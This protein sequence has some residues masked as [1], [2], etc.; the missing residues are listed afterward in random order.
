MFWQTLFCLSVLHI[1]RGGTV[2]LGLMAE[3]ALFVQPQVVLKTRSRGCERLRS[4]TVKV[5]Q[6]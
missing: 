6:W 2:A 4:T 5:I 3:Q 1:D